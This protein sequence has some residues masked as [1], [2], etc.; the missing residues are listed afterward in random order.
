MSAEQYLLDL[1]VMQASDGLGSE[2]LAPPVGEVVERLREGILEA[3]GNSLGLDHALRHFRDAL[4]EPRYFQRLTDT[5]TETGIVERCP[6]DF[7]HR[8]GSY[9][10]ASH[11]PDLVRDLERVRERARRN[12]TGEPT[13]L[14]RQRGSDSGDTQAAAV[15]SAAR[16][17]IPC[18]P[19]PASRP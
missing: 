17:D 1:E 10:P 14:G 4:S 3:G 19:P 9:H 8:L 13:E 7:A 18:S 6:V 16:G 2:P 5:R 15:V 11:P 12:L